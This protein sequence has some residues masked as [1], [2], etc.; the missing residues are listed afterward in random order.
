MCEQRGLPVLYVYSDFDEIVNSQHSADFAEIF[1]AND[2]KTDVY[3]ENCQPIHLH[4]ESGRELW[5]LTIQ[6]MV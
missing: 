6:L 3:D 5:I 4:S 1:G 2:D